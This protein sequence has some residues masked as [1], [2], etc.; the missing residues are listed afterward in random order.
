MGNGNPT[1][2]G[3]AARTTKVPP[4]SLTQQIEALKKKQAEMV[5]YRKRVKQVLRN[6]ERKKRRLKE[7][8]RALTDDDLLAVMR[9][10]EERK[11]EV[12]QTNESGTNESLSMEGRELETDTAATALGEGQTDR[13]EEEEEDPARSVTEQS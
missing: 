2:V 9:L 8:A 1:E 11:Q 12:Q 6:A 5:A 4:V 10:R 13:V 3:E 7:K